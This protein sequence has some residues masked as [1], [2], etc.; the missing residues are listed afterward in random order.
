M[1][2]KELLNKYLGIKYK[3]QGRSKE[4][5]LDCWG[6]IKFVYEDL[7]FSLWDINADYDEHW[8]WKGRNYFLENYAKEWIKVKRPDLF[9]LVLFHNRRN[10]PNHIGV[11]LSNYRFIHCC[12]QGVI[13]SSVFSWKDK[14]FAFYRLKAR[15]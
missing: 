7:G 9:D 14:L 11:L 10:I 1:T 5:G 2:E 12:K 13:V 15:K 4:E 3:H 8:S 6:F